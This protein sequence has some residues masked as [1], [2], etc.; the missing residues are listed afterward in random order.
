MH[1]E[2]VLAALVMVV[3][4]LVAADFFRRTSG[5]PREYPAGNEPGN[6]Q[7]PALDA[8][9]EAYPASRAGS[10]A[11][12]ASSP[13]YEPAAAA[14]PAGARQD[15]FNMHFCSHPGVNGR[16]SREAGTACLP[17]SLSCY[18]A[19]PGVPMPTLAGIR[20][21]FADLHLPGEFIA[22][23]GLTIARLQDPATGPSHRTSASGIVLRTSSAALPHR[24]QW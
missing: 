10:A 22:R 7:G 14:S 8:G 6:E 5:T 16:L 12:Q 11:F 23:L 1:V 9:R 21:I 2:I 18:E 17:C 19:R 13:P 20:A 4:V 24:S 3:A 15:D